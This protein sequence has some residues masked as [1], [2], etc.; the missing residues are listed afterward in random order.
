MWG[1]ATCGVLLHGIL[2]AIDPFGHAM[3]KD[4]QFTTS[5]FSVTD[6][7]A[8]IEVAMLAC[9]LKVASVI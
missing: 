6:V 4:H 7:T 8:G 3:L 5:R 1:N 2:H 9:D